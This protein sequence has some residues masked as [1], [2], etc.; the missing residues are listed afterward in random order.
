MIL[1]VERILKG[2]STEDVEF[3]V[4]PE[5]IQDLRIRMLLCFAKEFIASN[6]TSKRS[7]NINPQEIA[8]DDSTG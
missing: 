5:E 8:N 1:F 7:N 6:L 2:K 4:T 3:V